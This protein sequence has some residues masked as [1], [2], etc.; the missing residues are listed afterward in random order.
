MQNAREVTAMERRAR[1]PIV[2]LGIAALLAATPLGATL[3]EP[4]HLVYGTPT[5][6]GEPLETGVVTARLVGSGESI[7]SYTIGA[8]P[9]IPGQYVLRI[10]ID[11]VDPRLPGRAREGEALQLYVDG[12]PAGSTTVGER[13]TVQFL[14][15][16]QAEGGLPKISIADL[17]VYEGNGGNTIFSFAVTLDQV[18]TEDVTFDWATQ[19]D[20]AQ[21]AIDYVE[22]AA[23]TVGTIAAGN[24]GTTLAVTVKGD[25]FLEANDTFFVNLS[26]PSINAVILDG[27][28]LGTILDD[29][30]PPAISIADAEVIEG[31]AG[32][33]ALVF[34]LTTTRPIAQPITVNWVTVDQTATTGDNDY[35]PGGGVATFLANATATTVTVQVVGDDDNEEDETLL[36]NLSGQSGNATIADSQAVGTIRDDDGFLT[37]V[38]AEGLGELRAPLFGVSHAAVSPDGSHVYVTG[39]D[40]DGLAVYDRDAV[41]GE[42]E[43]VVVI[44]DGEDPGDGPID[45]L[46]G[47]EAVVVSPDGAHVYVAGYADGGVA[48]FARDAGTGLLDYLG[49]QL[50]DSVLGSADGLLGA[51]ALALS[52]DG[53]F[54]YAAGALEDEIAVFARDDD[55][56]SPTFGELTFVGVV[57]DNADGIDGLDGVESLAISADGDHLYAASPIDRAVAA[58][59][60]NPVTGELAFVAFYQDD[61]NGVDGL[62]GA[63]SVA[64]AP[65]GGHVYATG[66]VED[67]MAIFSRDDATGALGFLN[68]LRDDTNGVDGLDGATGVTVSFDNRFVYVCG[69][70][71]DSLTVFDR[72]G[73]T[74]A[75]TFREIQRDGFGANDGLARANAVAVSHDDQHLYVAGENDDMVAVFMRDAIAPALPAP[76]QSSSHTPAL[77]P[78]TATSWSNDPT[79]DVFWPAAVDNPGGTGV[80]GYSI[81]WDDQALT[82]LDGTVELGAAVTSTTS[83]PLPDD[84]DPYYFHL[85]ACDVV[86][87]CSPTGHLGG[88]F[89]DTTPPSNPGTITSTSHVV[90]VPTPDTT[91][92][93]VWA[94]PAADA[95]SGADG[96]SYS[97]DTTA[98]PV[99]DQTKDLE[100]TIN[101]VTSAALGDGPWWFHLCTRDNAGNWSAAAT[102]GPYVVE[103]MPPQV[104]GVATVADTGDGSLDPGDQTSASITQIL[105]AFSEAVA[106]PGGNA[107]ADDVTNPANFPLV[108]PG[109]DGVFQTST[110]AGLAGD[111][112]AATVESVSYDAASFTA[113]VRVRGAAV[114]TALDAGRYR[115]IACGSTS[116]VDAT[117]GNPLDGDG[118]GTGGDDYNLDFEVL[119]TNS[120]KNPNFDSGLGSWTLVPAAGGVVTFSANDGH[121]WATSGS[122]RA[123]FSAADFFVGVTQCVTVTELTSYQLQARVFV[124]TTS[125]TDPVLYGQAQ[126]FGAAN[127]SNPMPG[128]LQFSSTTDGDSGPAWIELSGAVSAPEDA[129]SARISFYAERTTGTAFEA[130]FDHLRLNLGG[131]IYAGG[132]ESGDFGGWSDAVGDLP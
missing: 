118:N 18:A 122:A 71:E 88:F 130:W 107:G 7:A 77:P 5:H 44:Y 121:G 123:T 9:L 8:N 59:T 39:R 82:N 13:G 60:R 70:F 105:V 26:N 67:A 112:Q 111:D 63:N 47:A 11:S 99:C 76:I 115:L 103:T 124:E 10:P 113:S 128:N 50:D 109:G 52:P 102:L 1:N 110:C 91:I 92:T 131:V 33:V 35:Q 3:P 78:P 46:N 41:T 61:Q 87:N 22:V 116:I 96:F 14:N 29:D 73:V 120:L 36:V 65:D 84:I 132:F 28:A 125:A 74:G 51:S 80:A 114:G 30:N 16:D 126:F 117:V 2:L 69:Y 68:A 17:A 27:Q 4:D 37:F 45:G 31:D 64:V 89:I 21:P 24:L 48:A 19:A 98:A 43:L 94:L 119:A 81:L 104:A 66:A 25:V 106:D 12:V 58:F 32:L 75:L 93:M 57:S 85:R 42:L 55:D 86:G 129:L 101:T 49:V 97:F 95:L 56:L 90:S 79:V 54:L 62:D 23:G 83:P 34:N 72:D 127:C 38:E 53:A 20:T 40:D 100:E 108:R 15:V 6:N